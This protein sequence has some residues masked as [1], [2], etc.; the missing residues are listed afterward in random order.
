MNSLLLGLLLEMD[1]T[2]GSVTVS[3]FLRDLKAL[4]DLRKFVLRIIPLDLLCL[5]LATL[6]QI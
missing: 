2:M 3:H 4:S 5:R 6:V 1:V